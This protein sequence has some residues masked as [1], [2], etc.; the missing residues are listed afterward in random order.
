M[1]WTESNRSSASI[2][3]S[4]WSRKNI[5]FQVFTMVQSFL[6][7]FLRISQSSVFTGIGEHYCICEKW[8]SKKYLVAPKEA[9][10]N[11]LNYLQWSPPVARLH[12]GQ[13]RHQIFGQALHFY[14]THYGLIMD[15]LKTNNQNR[16]QNDWYHSWF[17]R[18]FQNLVPTLPTM[19]VGY[20]VMSPKSTHTIKC[21]FLWSHKT[22]T[23]A[24]PKTCKYTLM[25]KISG[26][27]HR[28]MI[29]WMWG[30]NSV[31]IV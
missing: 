20:W 4:H 18:P 11:L 6:E 25:Y 15:S 23:A 12:F 29:N 9:A 13:C 21:S 16:W 1:A 5:T 19:Q 30:N 14:N 22:F 24:I 3:F 17:L 28:T 31:D 2:S 10:N 26:L 8:K 7:S 27:K